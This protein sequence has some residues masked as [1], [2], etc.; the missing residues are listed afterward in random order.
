MGDVPADGVLDFQVAVIALA[1][2][3]DSRFRKVDRGALPGRRDHPENL[4]VARFTPAA[5]R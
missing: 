4:G 5:H 2:G 1:Q 3:Y